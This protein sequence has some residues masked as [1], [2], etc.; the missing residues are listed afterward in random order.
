MPDRQGPHRRPGSTP[1]PRSP[2][3]LLVDGY[4]LAHAAP[5]LWP[6]VPQ[7]LEGTR[8]AVIQSLSA[9]TRRTGGSVVL[10]FD[11]GQVPSRPS[12][13]PPLV[14]VVFS[15]PPDKADDV[16]K[17]ALRQVHGSRR[18]RLV[19][20]DGELRRWARRHGIRSTSAAEFVEELERP[21][22]P[23]KDKPMPSRELDPHLE[24]DEAEVDE[25]AR[26][27]AGRQAKNNRGRGV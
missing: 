20:S 16:I 8:R 19:S 2:E 5:H 24:L 13:G 9:W 21:A 23:A 26:L 27:F 25:W 17:Q 3:E 11:G 12:P 22:E 18:A 6:G 7:D 1:G 15:R 4:N 10:V 14:E